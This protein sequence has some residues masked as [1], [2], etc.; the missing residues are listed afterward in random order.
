MT[1]TN[2]TSSIKPGNQQDLFPATANDFE[3]SIRYT[4]YNG[5]WHPVIME[6]ENYICTWWD[7]LQVQ[8]IQKNQHWRYEI[9]RNP[10]YKG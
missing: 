10:D 8:L 7:C 5:T 1:N 4:D 6:N 2:S 3:Y 9:K